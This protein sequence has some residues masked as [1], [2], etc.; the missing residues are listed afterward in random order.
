MRK[1][2]FPP[3]PRTKVAWQAR[4]K[5]SE[6]K[7]DLI[8]PELHRLKCFSVLDVGCNAGAVSRRVSHARF[9]VGLD[10]NLDTSGFDNPF[11]GVALGQVR[12]DLPFLETIPAFD[13][14]LLL[15]VHH[16]WYAKMPHK[17]ADSL[18][19]ALINK[20][21]KAVFVEFAAI[22]EKYGGDQG[23]VDNQPESVVDYAMRFLTRFTKNEC[24]KY[25]GATPEYPGK[26]SYRYMFLID[27]SQ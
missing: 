11:D 22:N 8:E 15:S 9:V 7:A 21:K 20:A 18:F 6:I 16:Q 17:D 12:I 19:A 10:G 24:V 14:V 23:F 13:A 26:E 27:Q 4:R 25:L 2:G 3:R 5:N 1:L